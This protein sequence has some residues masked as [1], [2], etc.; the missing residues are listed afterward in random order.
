MRQNDCEYKEICQMPA[1]FC[2]ED[3]LDCPSYEVFAEYL[4]ELERTGVDT[5]NG[6]EKRNYQTLKSRA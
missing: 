6:E 4:D 3:P 2:P 1:E 5:D